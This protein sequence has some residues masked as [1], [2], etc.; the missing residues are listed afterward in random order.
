[1]KKSRA[2]HDIRNALA[3]AKTIAK[4][5]DDATNE[6]RAMLIKKLLANL[7]ELE[8]MIEISIEQK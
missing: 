2:L 8:E 5:L 6:E 1:V 4:L 7:E 3:K